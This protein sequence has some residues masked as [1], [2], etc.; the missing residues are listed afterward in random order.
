MLKLTKKYTQNSILQSQE[1]RELHHAHFQP[2]VMAEWKRAKIEHGTN[3]AV[4]I[5]PVCIGKT[6]GVSGM[7]VRKIL[8][9]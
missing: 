9:W 3:M 8:F 1:L 6:T 5:A 2:C 4:Q 7:N